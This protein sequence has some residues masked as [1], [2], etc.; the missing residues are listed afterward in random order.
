MIY[1]ANS[2]AAAF[3]KHHKF[4]GS[5]QKQGYLKNSGYVFG[6]ETNFPALWLQ[7]LLPDEA[8]GRAAYSL[9]A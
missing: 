3:R 2:A 8:H 6:N 4:S 5:L 1:I 7:P 9:F